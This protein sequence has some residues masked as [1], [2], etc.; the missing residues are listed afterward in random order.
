LKNE[1][2]SGSEKAKQIPKTT[3]HFHSFRKNIITATNKNKRN[4]G[5]KNNPKTLKNVK[6]PGLKWEEV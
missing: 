1:N 2:K 6:T 5:K 3:N 4:K